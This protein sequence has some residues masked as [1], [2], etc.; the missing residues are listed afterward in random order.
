MTVNLDDSW[1]ADEITPISLC[2]RV[3]AFRTA[4]DGF[5]NKEKTRL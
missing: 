3:Y 2:L 4:G 1:T 5:A